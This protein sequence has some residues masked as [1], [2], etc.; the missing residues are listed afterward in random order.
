MKCIVC[1]TVQPA[2]D[3]GF[4]EDEEQQQPEPEYR[5][6]TAQPTYRTRLHSRMSRDWQF[7]R[8]RMDE[9][10][11]V[12]QKREIREMWTT[13]KQEK[14]SI[15]H[16]QGVKCP[17]LSYADCQLW[18]Y[19]PKNYPWD[20]RIIVFFWWELNKPSWWKDEWVR[21][22]TLREDVYIG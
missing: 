3:I 4:D 14:Y 9:A 1:G 8:D 22:E 18:A 5:G 12:E 20:R 19:D 7:F 10:K 11:T 17:P 6:T 21:V 2:F 15:R 13:F 16:G